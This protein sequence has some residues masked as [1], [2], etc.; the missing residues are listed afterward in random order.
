[1]KSQQQKIEELRAY[2]KEAKAKQWTLELSELIER[3]GVTRTDLNMLMVEI[4]F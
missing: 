3:F 4:F 2:L 1:M